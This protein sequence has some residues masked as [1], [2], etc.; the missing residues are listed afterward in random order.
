METS[1][2]PINGLGDVLREGYGLSVWT[3]TVSEQYFRGAAPGTDR[4]TLWGE[5]VTQVR[6]R[7]PPQILFA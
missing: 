2:V 3:G 4:A 7:P 6:L 5:V 1:S